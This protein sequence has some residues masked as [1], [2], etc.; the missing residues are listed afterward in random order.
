MIR[1]AQGVLSELSLLGL[2]IL[3]GHHYGLPATAGF[4]VLLSHELFEILDPN[5]PFHL[6]LLGRL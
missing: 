3:R 6:W 2:E 1:D 4:S 5:E